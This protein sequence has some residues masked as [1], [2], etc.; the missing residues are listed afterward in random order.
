M[1]DNRSDGSH[2]RVLVV[3]DEDKFRY[4]AKKNLAMRGF[5]VDVAEASEEA[6]AQ[7]YKCN[8]SVVL[9]DVMMPGLTGDELVKMITDWRPEIKVIMVTAHL[10]QE[11]EEECYRNGAY[12]YIQKPVDFD[13]ISEMIKEATL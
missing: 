3:D 2:K 1:T 8:P 12:A 11:A 7:I 10:N 5:T 6:I 9:L 13:K 4:L